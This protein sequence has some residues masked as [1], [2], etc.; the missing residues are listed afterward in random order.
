[1]NRSQPRLDTVKAGLK[2]RY[3]KERAFKTLGIGAILTALA[4]LAVLF[5]TIIGSGYSA[6]QQTFVRLEFFLDSELLDPDSTGNPEVL[7]QADYGGLVKKTLRNMFPEVIHA[8]V[9]Q[10]NRIKS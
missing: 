5:V 6:F 7:S 9:H 2:K 3:A 1:M 8:D 10:F 4:M